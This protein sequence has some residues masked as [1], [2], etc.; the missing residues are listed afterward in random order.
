MRASDVEKTKGWEQGQQSQLRYWERWSRQSRTDAVLRDLA[1]RAR[2]VRQMIERTLGCDFERARILE[3]GAALRPVVH[4]LPGRYRVC[5]DPLMR[6]CR[7][8]KPDVFTSGVGHFEAVAER[9]PFAGE[10]FDVCVFL[11]AIDVCIEQAE[12]VSELARVLSGSGTLV[13]SANTYGTVSRA[14]RV[15]ACLTGLC[16]DS[17]SYPRVF[18]EKSFRGLVG[19]R[20][21][22][23]GSF[24][25]LSVERLSYRCDRTTL[26]ARK[27][28][29]T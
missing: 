16:R 11:N 15:A 20:F 1:E 4:F 8:L 29:S 17:L 3:V 27:R 19:T 24:A 25:E 12:A 28:A 7:A 10:S 14:V 2:S 13:I 9:L 18:S 5:V 6:Q 23:A 22:V 21:E 26:L